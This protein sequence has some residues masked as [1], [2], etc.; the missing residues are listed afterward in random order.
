M[1][2]ARRINETTGELSIKGSFTDIMDEYKYI[3]DELLQTHFDEFM[4][5]MDRWNEEVKARN[6]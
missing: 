4:A 6:D 3:T 1:I 2:Y 5:E